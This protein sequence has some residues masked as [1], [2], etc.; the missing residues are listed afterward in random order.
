M[1]N[2]EIKIILTGLLFVVITLLLFYAGYLF[3]RQHN[4]TV[5]VDMTTFET[6][7]VENEDNLRSFI[8]T[9]LREGQNYL[10]LAKNREKANERENKIFEIVEH[11]RPDCI[12]TATLAVT[13]LENPGSSQ[14]NHTKTGMYLARFYVLTDEM[15]KRE[16]ES[17]IGRI[18]W[19]TIYEGETLES[20]SNYYGCST[21]DISALNH[22]ENPEQIQPG[23]SIKVIRNKFY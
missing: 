7:D 15:L 6:F 22:I 19:H 21:I 12:G 5:I 11:E 18:E 9:E 13:G 14:Y 2:R 8:K 20:I 16:I 23:K 1:K 3:G 17:K 4:E 10:I